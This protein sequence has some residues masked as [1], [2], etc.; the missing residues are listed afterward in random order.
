MQA[1]LLYIVGDDKMN[2]DNEAV[3]WDNEK[4]V[5]RAKVIAEEINKA[6]NIKKPCSAME[7]GCG[8]GLISFNLYDRFD[9]IT[10]V[11]TSQ[12][13]I[14]ALNLKIKTQKIKNMVAYKLDIN[15]EQK[16]LEKFDVIYTSM[17]LHH[18]LD[19]ERTLKSLYSLLKEDGC[20]CIVDL[21]EEDGSFHSNYENYDGHNGFNQQEL[22]SMMKHIGFKE[23][24]SKIIYRDIKEIDDK[25]IDYSLFLMKGIR[26]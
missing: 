16:D 1:F 10:L 21:D 17:V 5:M 26:E 18:I 3:N 20:L 12:G 13:M 15:E 8:T 7:F 9:T 24:S 6:L 22:G 19:T 11:D 14:D 23:V 4:R 25:R 2:F